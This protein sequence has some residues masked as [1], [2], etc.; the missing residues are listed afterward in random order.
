MP[1]R[2]GCCSSYKVFVP[3]AIALRNRL[4]SINNARGKALPAESIKR[5]SWAILAHVIAMPRRYVHQLTTCATSFAVD[6]AHTVRRPCLFGRRKLQ[7]QLQSSVPMC[8]AAQS[9][10]M[11]LPGVA[12]L[13]RSHRSPP[14]VLPTPPHHRDLPNRASGATPN[15]GR[16]MQEITPTKFH[17]IRPHALEPAVKATHLVTYRAACLS[18][19]RVLVM[20]TRTRERRDAESNGRSCRMRLCRRITYVCV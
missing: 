3:L 15:S 11:C 1:D 14:V 17:R 6:A 20:M 10:A 12:G 5:P 7:Q 19:K 13:A 2:I 8:G 16:E 9:L 4:Q 18:L